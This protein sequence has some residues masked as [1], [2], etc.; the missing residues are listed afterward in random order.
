MLLPR[1]G[2]RRYKCGM[3]SVALSEI[4]IVMLLLLQ[5][6]YWMAQNTR[7]NKVSPWG[8]GTVRAIG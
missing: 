3:S 6:C 1:T 4:D 7:E 5:A 2:N 8:L